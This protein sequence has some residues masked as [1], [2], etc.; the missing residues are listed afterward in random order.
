MDIKKIIVDFIS[1]FQKS[2]KV[3]LDNQENT[4]ENQNSSNSE[5]QTDSDVAQQNENK[6]DFLT[7][8]QDNITKVEKYVEQNPQKSFKYTSIFFAVI[9]GMFVFL[10]AIPSS[11]QSLWNDN[12][13]TNTLKDKT[14]Q[15]DKRTV[16]ESKTRQTLKLSLI[17]KKYSREQ[18]MAYINN[19]K[20]YINKHIGDQLMYQ[21]IMLFV[22]ENCNNDINDNSRLLINELLKTLMSHEKHFN[23]DNVSLIGIMDKCVQTTWRVDLPP[24]IKL[25]RTNLMTT[26]HSVKYR[27]EE[28]NNL[29]IKYGKENVNPKTGEVM[30]AY[31]SDFLINTEKE[32]EERWAKEDYTIERSKIDIYSALIKLYTEEETRALFYTIMR[33]Y[34]E[35]FSF[36]YALDERERGKAQ[37]T[38][39]RNEIKNV[40]ENDRKRKENNS[41]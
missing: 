39:L 14:E 29:M 34:A 33:D 3:P 19:M 32:R 12:F 7:K 11:W 20:G 4:Y 41:K 25:A 35:D 21:E 9:I 18:A 31:K 15:E 8:I 40:L 2:D 28:I 10:L 13:I 27:S 17:D 1:R 30:M 24:F 26:L 37:A 22:S 5:K 36:F 6:K 38:E 16:D 23:Q